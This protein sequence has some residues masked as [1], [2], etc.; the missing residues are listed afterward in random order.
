MWLYSLKVAQLLRSAACLHTNQSRSYLNHLVRVYGATYPNST[1]C[2]VFMVGCIIKQKRFYLWGVSPNFLASL[3]RRLRDWC[4]IGTETGI[5][6]STS[7]FPCPYIPAV[8]HTH[9]SFINYPRNIILAIESV[10][11]QNT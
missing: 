3:S 11:Q 5:F 4:Q 8:L 9:I 10:V 7:D 1:A 6:P 2:R